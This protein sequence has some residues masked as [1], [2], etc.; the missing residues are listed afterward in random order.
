MYQTIIARFPIIK[1][2]SKFVVVGVINTAIDFIVLNVEMAATHITSGPFMFVLN[3][4]SFSAATVNSYFMNKYWTFEDKSNQKEG[5]KF[6]QFF[7]VSI[8][9]ITINGAVVYFM[10][11]FLSPLGGINAQL[12]ANVAKIVATGFS[13]VW[14]FIGYKFIVFKK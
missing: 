4:V 12:W 5:A 8:I 1:Q 7:V 6:S 10:T 9:G 14:N 2:F 11:T 3:S 13:L